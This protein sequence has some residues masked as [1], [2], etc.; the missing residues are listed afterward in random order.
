[1]TDLVIIQDTKEQQPLKFKDVDVI[2]SGLK[3][4]DY[5]IQGYENR[6][7]F[8][9][10]T[11]KDLIGTCDHNKVKGKPQS[12]YAR[13]SNELARM[14]DGF[15]FYAIVISGYADDILPQCYKIALMQ[16]QAGFKKIV[17]PETRA[18]GVRGS[19]ESLRARYNCHFYF[20]GTK[21]LTA[22]WIVKQAKWF[23]KHQGQ[24]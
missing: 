12:N 15:D 24:K 19:L 1:V 14:K 2:V 6:V 18:K 22:E 21:E 5:S 20:L 11:I 23:L 13:F 16:E 17:K 4:A 7:C 8:E 10:K 3:T 9:H